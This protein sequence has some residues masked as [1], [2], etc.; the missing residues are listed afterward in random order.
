MDER[1]SSPWLV[2]VVALA[3]FINGCAVLGYERFSNPSIEPEAGVTFGGNGVIGLPGMDLEAVANTYDHSPFFLL[4]IVVPIIPFPSFLDRPQFEIDL[5][6]DPEGEDFTFDPGRVSVRVAD[7]P[8]IPPT[9]FK[10]GPG[11]FDVEEPPY[12]W[13]FHRSPE[14]SCLNRFPYRDPA[15]EDLPI[16]APLPVT[17]RSC[18][19]LIFDRR[20]PSPREPLL[21]SIG[22]ISKAGQPFP[23]PPIRFE[24][25]WTMFYGLMLVFN[26]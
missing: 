20:A 19:R 5:I 26:T 16:S 15:P 10:H 11:A 3:L 4:G 6:L 18:F 13:S 24:K 22:G 17:E 21:L 9:T 23:V 2:P 14:V 8:A 7:G 1:K 12:A 25:G